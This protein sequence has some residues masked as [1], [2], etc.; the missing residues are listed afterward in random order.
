MSSAWGLKQG[1]LQWES[2]MCSAL[3]QKFLGPQGATRAGPQKIWKE[4]LHKM[5]FFII[6]NVKSIK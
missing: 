6:V 4:R 5:Y 2:Y 3:D 1:M